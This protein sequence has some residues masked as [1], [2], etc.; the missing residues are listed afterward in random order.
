MLVG[1][2]F[3][4]LLDVTWRYYIVKVA[5]K[6]FSTTGVAYLAIPMGRM[7]VQLMV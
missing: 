6:F 3:T 1:V 5:G 4:L 7:A 2:T